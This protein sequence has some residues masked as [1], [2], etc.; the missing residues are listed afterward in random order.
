M[1]ENKGYDLVVRAILE[2]KAIDLSNLPEDQKKNFDLAAEDLD[3]RGF[4]L[5]AAKVFGMTRNFKRLKDVA[6]LCLKEKKLGV[7]FFA[8]TILEDVDGL[9]QTGEAYLRV[10]DVEGA[11]ACYEAAKNEMMS[12]FIKVN[13]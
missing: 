13:F 11:L 12:S 3:S 4:Y 9:N 7:A 5:E 10:P 2:G 6:N 1:S 8:F